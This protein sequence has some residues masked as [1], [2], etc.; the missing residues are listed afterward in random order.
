MHAE[1]QAAAD[2]GRDALT[3]L[4]G[5]GRA[6]ALRAIASGCS[7]Q[8]LAARLHVSAP[9]ASAQAAVLREAGLIATLRNGRS[10]QHTATTLGARLLEANPKR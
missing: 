10:V 5:R 3:V 7:T 2:E 9:S 8:E 1:R 4:L 6:A